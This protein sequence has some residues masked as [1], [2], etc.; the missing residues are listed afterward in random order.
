MNI[1]HGYLLRV[2]NHDTDKLISNT[3]LYILYI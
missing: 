2:D 3:L 1:D